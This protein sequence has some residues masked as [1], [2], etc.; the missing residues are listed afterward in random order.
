[1]ERLSALILGFPTVIY[2]V[3][4]VVALV[5]WIF[6]VLGALDLDFLGGGHADADGALEGAAKGLA[7]GAL[8]GA[9]KG[10]TESALEG[11]AKGLAEGALEG[12]TKGVAEGAIKGVVEGSAKAAGETLANHAPHAPGV[13]M[14][15]LRFGK[16]P[17]TVIFTLFVAFGWLVSALSMRSLAPRWEAWSLPGWALG[18]P[19][20][21]AS[22]L[23]SFVLTKLAVRPLEP[24]FATHQ[25]TSRRDLVGRVCVIS[26]GHVDRR[27]GQATLED[28][29]AGLILQ[30]R[31]D[32]K[33]ALRRGDRALIIAWDEDSAGFLVEPMDPLEREVVRLPAGAAATGPTAAA[34]ADEEA[35]A[36]PARGRARDA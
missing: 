26:T 8:E 1:M 25:A 14:F 19:V 32:A 17:V 27:F 30:V 29:G 15:T 18:V 35:A 36:E 20:L 6:V 24:F 22:M 9:T 4:L 13:G 23:V 3:L 33:G 12:A 5:Y 34:E 21:A 10:V 11:A 31:C 16:A 28:G 2:T 7:D